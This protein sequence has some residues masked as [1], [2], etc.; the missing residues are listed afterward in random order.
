VLKPPPRESYAYVGVLGAFI[1]F[2]KL[3][4]PRIQAWEATLP[5]TVSTL[6]GVLGFFVIV[7]LVGAF[8][9][10]WIGKSKDA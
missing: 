1:L 9:L 10:T 5:H 7:A 3:F 6:I 4:G 8:A 2:G